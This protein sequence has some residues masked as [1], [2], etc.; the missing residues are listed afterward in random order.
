MALAHTHN[1]LNT[2]E[3]HRNEGATRYTLTS[4]GAGSKDPGDI[5]CIR[6]SPKPSLPMPSPRLRGRALHAVL[7]LSRTRLG[8]S[9]IRAQAFADYGFDRLLA[10]DPT[11]LAPLS[12]EPRPLQAGANRQ[13]DAQSLGSPTPSSP[14]VTVARL[15]DAFAAGA[16]TPSDVLATL[17]KTVESGAFGHVTWSPYVHTMW[18]GAARDAAASDA[19]W[20]AGSPR[21][22][23]DGIPVPV[24]DEVHVA[25]APTRGGTSWRVAPE[26]EDGFAVR[27]LRDAG[28]IIYAKTHTTEWGMSPVGMQP[29]GPFPRNAHAPDRAA[30]GS[31]SGTGAAVAL[32]HAPV[33]LGSDGG[34]SIRIPSALQGL[35]GL[36]PTFQ[37]IGR[38]GDVFGMGTV[39]VLGP[40]G[41]TTADVVAFM[42]ALA[43]ARDPDDYACAYAPAGSPAP[44][45]DR[46]LGRGIR[47]AKIGVPRSLWALADT[48]IVRQCEQAL[49][50]L[51][52]DGARIIE[53]D[54]PML[55]HAHAIGVLSIGP[56][57]HAALREL[58][59]SHGH[60]AGGELQLQLALLGSV[61][62]SDYLWAQR[63]RATLRREVQ[64]A[65][66]KLDLI[67]LPT[68]ATV[69][70]P[71]P[72][73]DLGVDVADDG[74]VR[75][76]CA[77]AFAANLTGLPAGTAPVGTAGGLPVGLQ[78]MGDAWDEA[79]VI[80]AMAQVERIGLS[81]R[82]A[83]PAAAFVL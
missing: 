70:P 74:A 78:F 24:K 19:R 68:T 27:A 57:T 39:S 44:G 47:G 71:Y 42:T 12:A 6:T 79:S 26:L 77:F 80:A 15:R 50:A 81:A 73:R 56:E 82:P 1:V 5:A 8:L 43:E 53:I 30:G 28:A 64:R 45:W 60:L 63:A 7:S 34:G 10:L 13:W 33:G 32:G 9:A 51:E 83:P 54:V 67:A 59:A 3:I 48:A 16:S 76:M 62:A 55:A 72:R 25:G 31:S 46:A 58:E 52:A 35:F 17:R 20:R 2:I 4:A 29:H 18:E 49:G 40:L 61:S 66:K 69:A 38:S 22:A 65:F 41:Q 36:K 11:T 23:L 14:L 75:A 21:S 37:R